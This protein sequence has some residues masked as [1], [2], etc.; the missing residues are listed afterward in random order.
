MLNKTPKQR[1]GS[2]T[3]AFGTKAEAALPRGM[4]ALPLKLYMSQGKKPRDRTSTTEYTFIKY[5]T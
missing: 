3:G 5:E 1:T 4:M 2:N